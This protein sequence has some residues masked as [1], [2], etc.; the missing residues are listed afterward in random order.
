MNET[1][2]DAVV[3]VTGDDTGTGRTL[4]PLVTPFADG[5]ETID[6]NALSLTLSTTSSMA[7]L[8][9][10]V[11]LP[12][13]G[14]DFLVGERKCLDACDGRCHTTRSCER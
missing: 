1:P 5:G 8:R 9:L 6:H 7:V 3:G 13:P 10:A 2:E 12:G 11:P 4:C 14:R